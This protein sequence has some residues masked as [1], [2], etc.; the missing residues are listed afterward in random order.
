MILHR[1]DDLTKAPKGLPSPPPPAPTPASPMPTPPAPAAAA[2]AQK[3]GAAE[4]PGREG[5]RL[6]PGLT[7]VVPRGDEGVRQRPGSIGTSIPG[8]V[9]GAV[10][11]LERD[12]RVG[13]PTGTGHN[14]AGFFFDPQGADFTVWLNHAKN[15]LYRN[16]IIP[17]AANLGFRGHADFEFTIERDG[18]LSSLKLLKSSGTA[19]LDRAAQYALTGSRYM[20][21][22]DDYRPARLT[23]QVSFYYNEAP[24]GS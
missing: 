18:T 2:V 11:Q 3:G 15:E 21:L 23:I 16:W 6:P 20:P 4:T 17:E 8:A 1:D 13:I 12:A 5:L 7:G 14:Q 24:T 9:E 22:P 10:R 19:S